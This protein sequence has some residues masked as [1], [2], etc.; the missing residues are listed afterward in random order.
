MKKNPDS[1]N[2]ILD[3]IKFF[4]ENTEPVDAELLLETAQKVN[5]VLREEVSL[6]RPHLSDVD[7]VPGGLLDFS[8]HNGEM[9]VGACGAGSTDGADEKTSVDFPDGP[10]DVIVVP[11]LHARKTLIY[12]LLCANAP[13]ASEKASADTSKTIFDRL[14]EGS[15]MLVFLGD[16]LHS[17]GTQKERWAFAYQEYLDGNICSEEMTS[18]MAD[19]LSTLMQVML[20]KTAFS[21]SVHCLKGNHEN[22]RNESGEG[23]FA[24]R[25][26]VE[27]GTMV[28]D[29]MSEVY[30]KKVIDQIASFEKHLPLVCVFDN[31]ILS[32]AE[33]RRAHSRQEIIDS[34]VDFEVILDF[35]WTANG[36]ACSKSAEK[37]FDELCPDNGIKKCFITGHRPVKENYALRQ[38]GDVVQIHN[39]YKMQYAYIKA[40]SGFN[41]EKD[42]IEL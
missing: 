18:E 38:D 42:I 13:D 23:N 31:F 12:K 19:G 35:T 8:S 41:P 14:K 27:E 7:F 29:Y 21:K 16:I 1:K 33:P 9:Q 10:R 4:S 36:E 15:L 32:H 30:G 26:F 34:A 25:K 28:F 24:F 3:K 20:L 2:D 6:Y 11:D 17:E 5:E 22:I 40:H 39:P 37:Y